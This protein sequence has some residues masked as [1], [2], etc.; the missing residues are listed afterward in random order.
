MRMVEQRDDVD[1]GK[2]GELP[3][4]LVHEQAAAVSRRTDRIG[5][6]KEHAQTSRLDIEGI[7][8]VADVDA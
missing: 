2:S 7:E 6:N 3:E 1:L 5:R 8:A 4:R